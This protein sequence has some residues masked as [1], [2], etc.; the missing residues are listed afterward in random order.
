MTILKN[1]MIPGGHEDKV[2]DEDEVEEVE[3]EIE[4]V[5]V[6]EVAVKVLVEY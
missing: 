1:Y 4:E 5:E 6:D 3:V 2:Y